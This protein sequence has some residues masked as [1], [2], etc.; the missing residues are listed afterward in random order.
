MQVDVDLSGE[1]P[2][3][4]TVSRH[5]AQLLLEPDGRFWLRCL[6]RRNVFVNGRQ[7]ERGAALPLPHLSLIKAGG[8][9]LLFMVN[10]A[11]V[12]RLTRRSAALSVL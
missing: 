2:H 6:G 3:A 12:Q 1:G 11:A 7:L 10:H 4:Q 8:V 5:Q 9:A